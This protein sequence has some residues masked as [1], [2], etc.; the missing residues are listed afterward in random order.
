MRKVVIAMFIG[1]MVFTS[2]KK[3]EVS[4]EITEDSI[5]SLPNKVVVDG[6]AY[7]Q[8]D[9]TQ[10]KIQ[11]MPNAKVRVTIPYSEYGFSTSA[12]GN[13]ILETTTNKDGYYKIE[14]PVPA[15]SI[16]GVLSF[17]EKR[18]EVKRVDYN[19]VEEKV[20][21]VFAKSDEPLNGLGGTK[22][23]DVRV[24]VTYS[25]ATIDPNANELE[26]PTTEIK[27]SGKLEY[28]N[29]DSSAVGGTNIYKTVPAGT[30]FTVLIEMYDVNG[31]WYRETKQVTVKAGGAYEI[32]VPMVNN[33]RAYVD[34]YGEGFWTTT[35]VTPFETKK[36]LY[37]FY[38]D[39][40][41][42]AYNIDMPRDIKY[43]RD[44]F[45][46]DVED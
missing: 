19:G 4:K 37:H 6:W 43:S 3:Y 28:M 20:W 27:I 9:E 26:R 46:Q 14:V 45:I 17:E 12:T 41:F 7:A 16:N 35:V 29:I 8:L 11:P 36:K 23:N 24:N 33:G 13:L 30:P 39:H 5:K 1:T 38:L 18:C 25:I 10:S 22:I 15:K 2:C 40:G 31:R 21:A 44:F 32:A 42:T 34:L